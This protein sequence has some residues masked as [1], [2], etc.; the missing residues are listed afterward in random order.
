MRDVYEMIDTILAQPACARFIVGKVWAYFVSTDAPADVLDDL[1]QRFR[2]DAYDVRSL[3]S[4]VLRSRFFFSPR[5]I[6]QLVKN[7]MEF[8]VGAIRNLDRPVIEDY[9]LLGDHVEL[10][11]LPLHRYQTPAGLDGGLDWLDAQSVI[12]RANFAEQLTRMQDPYHIHA[13]YDA[14][15]QVNRLNLRTAEQIVDYFLGFLL[16]GRAPRAVR[17]FCL[18]FMN[19]VDWERRPFVFTQ[20]LANRKVRG[21]VHIIL[22]LP[23]YS[24]N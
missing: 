11:G 14:L 24:L 16:D 9:R 8:V 22:S 7:P 5:A 19:R 23:Q 10:M 1:A 17:D 20:D 4:I 3:M 12:Q 18:E 13:H 2:A 6:G 15:Y 21:L